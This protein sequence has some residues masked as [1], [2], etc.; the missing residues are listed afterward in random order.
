MVNI[1]RINNSE[2]IPD[3]LH[4][5]FSEYEARA[6]LA[7]HRLNIAT[8]YE[9]SRVAGLP[10]ANAYSVLESLTKKEAVQPVTESPL[11]YAA[12]DPAI[13]LN[14]II[15]TT[16]SRCTRLLATIPTA[17]EAPDSEYVWSISGRE[18]IAAKIEELIN[19]AETHIWVKT[20]ESILLPHV[21]A[22]RRAAKRGVS[23]LIILF[24][25]QIEKFQF[26]KNSRTYLH[27]RNGIA[28]GIAHHLVTLT[29][30][31]QQMLIA[32]VRAHGGSYTRDLPIV[33][34]A[35]SLIRHEVYFAEIFEAFGD[36]IHE[37]FGPS[38]I[39]LRRQYLP[40]E[41]VKNLEILLERLKTAETRTSEDGGKRQ[42]EKV[43]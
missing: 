9:V 13:L 35:D 19:S 24:G 23:I 43:R 1:A 27:E 22:L 36:L 10:K 33:A 2:L 21:D 20:D 16:T 15:E 41:Q 39:K 34:L 38:L 17:T 30:D 31:F 28:V 7:L 37:K 12:V 6:Y 5:G 32:D 14:R 8:A 25:T 29:T 26:G 42:R 18:A 11:R 40:R 3:L 4:L